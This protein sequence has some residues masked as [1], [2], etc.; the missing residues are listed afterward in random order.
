MRKA[1][2][3]PRP[4]PSPA[5]PGYSPT[6]FFSFIG[7]EIILKKRTLLLSLRVK[8]GGGEKRSATE[9]EGCDFGSFPPA[10]RSPQSPLIRSARSGADFIPPD[11]PAAF[12]RLSRVPIRSARAG[13]SLSVPRGA[14]SGRLKGFGSL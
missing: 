13:R 11:L 9:R 8:R 3:A 7:K 6:T 14:L 1:L 10:A 4:D 5:G 12:S 2:P